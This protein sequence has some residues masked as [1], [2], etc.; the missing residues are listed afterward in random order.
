M[1]LDK[2]ND[3]LTLDKV[4]IEIMYSLFVNDAVSPMKG[5]AIKDIMAKT[6]LKTSYFTILRRINEKLKTN[7][8]V[9]DGYKVGNSKSFY[10]SD[11]AISYLNENIL[12]KEDVYEY[13]E[14]D[15]S[16]LEDEG[17]L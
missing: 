17:D 10:L 7:G 4:D 2:T 14:V 6:S 3:A 8:Y 1:T 9:L 15:D 11:K 12:S 16:E 13:V 5:F